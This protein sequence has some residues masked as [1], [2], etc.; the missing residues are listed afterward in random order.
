MLIQKRIIMSQ[1]NKLSKY[2]FHIGVTV[3][4]LWIWYLCFPFLPGPDPYGASTNQWGISVFFL[5][6]SIYAPLEWMMQSDIG[7]RLSDLCYSIMDPQL[8]VNGSRTFVYHLGACIVTLFHSFLFYYSIL[9]IINTIQSSYRN[10]KLSIIFIILLLPVVSFLIFVKNTDL[11]FCSCSLFIISLA[12]KYYTN[13]K[14]FNTSTFILLL[15]FLSFTIGFRRNAVILMPIFIYMF[16]KLYNKTKSIQPRKSYALSILISVFLALP[17][18]SPLLM[19]IFN[20][21]NS[22]GEEVFMSSDYACMRLLEKKNIN[23]D[24]INGFKQDDKYLFMQYYERF[25]FSENMKKVWLNEIKNTPSLFFKVRV[26]N[27]IQFLSLGCLPDFVIDHLHANY[28]YVYFPNSNDFCT[29]VDFINNPRQRFEGSKH[30]HP[31]SDFGNQLALFKR[32]L[33]NYDL[34]YN[35]SIIA[36]TIQIF[37]ILSLICMSY[38]ITFYLIKRRKI[39]SMQK[40]ILWCGLLEIG[41]LMSFLVFTPTPDFRYHFFSI[42]MAFFVISLSI[43]YFSNLPSHIPSKET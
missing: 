15:I 6:S 2:L 13:K 20:I 17:F 35:W 33:F 12:F 27:Y 16:L 14:L 3:L 21:S 37:Y 7:S 34:Y 41:H 24:S 11:F 10:N 32:S 22:H 31:L 8:I 39:T 43:C 36:T 42:T 30:I 1:N 5:F 40:W 25:G 19:P 26:I 23:L 4:F 28:P 29:I 9:S 18:S 38:H